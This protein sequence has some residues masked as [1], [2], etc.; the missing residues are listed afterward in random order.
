MPYSE[1]TDALFIDE[2]RFVTY[3]KGDGL[4]I[5][6]EIQE[7]FTVQ[8]FKVDNLKEH[9]LCKEVSDFKLHSTDKDDSSFLLTSSKH[10]LKLKYESE[11]A[12]EE[13]IEL[14]EDI[15]TVEDFISV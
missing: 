14:K 13:K 3:S 5:V 9:E 1:I 2:K 6:W 4:F 11:L 12:L 8:V 7:E 10:S 15:S